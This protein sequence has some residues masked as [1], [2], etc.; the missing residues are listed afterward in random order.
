MG[1]LRDN[2]EVSFEKMAATV[3]QSIRELLNDDRKLFEV[4]A[5]ERSITHKFA[6]K[7]ARKFTKWDVDCE[8]NRVYDKGDP[9][10]IPSPGPSTTG[11][12]EGRTIYP[13]II[14][15]LRKQSQNLLV[16]EVKKSINKTTADATGDLEKIKALLCSVEYKYRFGLFVC[17]F[18]GDQFKSV[19]EFVNAVTGKW[20][21]AK[22]SELSFIEDF[23]L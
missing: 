13:D 3:A 10:R 23:T 15:H 12:T 5:N 4:D 22:G 14:V 8:Y 20:Y 1:H 19:S 18:T 9:K 11:D 17:F 7:L 16:I 2:P 21:R 6:E